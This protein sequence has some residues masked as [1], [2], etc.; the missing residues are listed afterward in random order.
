MNYYFL[1]ALLFLAA[2]DSDTQSDATSDT[3]GANGD[4]RVETE[5]MMDM[6]DET[7]SPAMDQEMS[8]DLDAGMA[9]DDA[10]PNM[11]MTPADSAPPS[12][13]PTELSP[14]PEDDA[15]YIY[16]QDVVHQFELVLTPEN[17]EI[18]DSDP[19]AEIYVPGTL[20]FEGVSYENVGV[21]YKGSAGAWINCV[22]G[23]TPENPWNFTGR[24]TCPKLGLK[25]SFNKY[26]SEGRFF[27]LK[28]LQFHAMNQDQSLMRERLGYWLFRQMGVAAPRANHVKV[29]LNGDR[30]GLYANIEYIDGRF[31]R[32]R[33]EDGKGNLYKEVWPTWNDFSGELTAAKLAQGLR[34]NEDENPSFANVLA[35]SDAMQAGSD[36]RAQALPE[37]MDIE[38]LARFIAVDRTIAADDGAFHFYCQRTG[39]ANHNFYVYE[40]DEGSNLWV[41]PWDL[42][43]AFVVL[44]PSISTI[45]DLFLKVVDA[46]YDLSVPCAPHEGAASWTPWQIPPICDPLIRTYAEHF[47]DDYRAAM[48]VLLDGPFSPEVVEEKLSEWSAQIAPIVDEVRGFNSEHISAQEWT[49]ALGNLRTRIGI[50]RQIASMQ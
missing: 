16:D 1:I 25:I 26:D 9:S 34:T 38:Y 20:I 43:N 32:S 45:A 24:I 23:S 6:G 7:P 47:M 28:K 27:G 13:D 39:C 29:S 3:A 36:A 37:W 15:A 19:A 4:Q 42:D 2:C 48:D 14:E 30:V 17:M 41:I 22:E 44:D 18:L 46:W 12:G 5:S 31:T 8:A 21:R 50:L 10:T 11:D 33:F 40:E 35:F 49:E